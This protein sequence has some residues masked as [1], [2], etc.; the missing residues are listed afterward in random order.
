M[1]NFLT[2]I[3]QTKTNY[4]KQGHSKQG[5]RQPRQFTKQQSENTSNSDTISS[6]K[7]EARHFKNNQGS[8]WFNMFE[9]ISNRYCLADVS[10]QAK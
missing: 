4:A 2:Q 5:K 7:V 1:K 3:N 8:V 9:S 10:K 6:L